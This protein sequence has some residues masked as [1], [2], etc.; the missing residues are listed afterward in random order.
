MSVS[1]YIPLVHI[2]VVFPLLFYIG[3]NIYY[4]NEMKPDF[5]LLVMMLAIVVLLYHCYK[6]YKYSQMKD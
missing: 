2:L 3:F 6:F 4:K 1:Y 5:G